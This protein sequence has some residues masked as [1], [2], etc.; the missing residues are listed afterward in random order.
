MDISAVTF[1]FGPNLNG[2]MDPRNTIKR[3]IIYKKQIFSYFH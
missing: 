2:Q 3:P 1:Q